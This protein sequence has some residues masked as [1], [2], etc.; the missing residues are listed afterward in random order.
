MALSMINAV[1]CFAVEFI[2]IARRMVMTQEAVTFIVVAV[3]VQ[4]HNTELAIS[5]QLIRE[6][7][8][9]Q[10]LNGERLAGRIGPCP[11]KRT[12]DR[13]PLVKTSITIPKVLLDFAEKDIT[14]EGFNS[15]S[16]YLAEL[17]RRRKHECELLNGRAR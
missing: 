8:I 6:N 14:G 7:S 3:W 10:D 5:R 2:R 16:A 1:V 9:S 15:L 17:I 12:K 4:R 11:M 13:V